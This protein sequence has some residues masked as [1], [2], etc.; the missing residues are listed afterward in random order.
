MPLNQEMMIDQLMPIERD[1]LGRDFAMTT[2]MKDAKRLISTRAQTHTK[3]RG[4][5]LLVMGA[6]VRG[7]I[8]SCHDSGTVRGMGVCTCII[9]YEAIKKRKQAQSRS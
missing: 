4:V 1:S 8:S 2:V 6:L 9:D 3:Y 5:S 7:F